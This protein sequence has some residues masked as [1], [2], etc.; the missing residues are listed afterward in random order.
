MNIIGISGRIG[1]GKDTVHQLLTQHYENM[2]Y[3]CT[4]L[5]FAKPIKDICTSMFDWDRERLEYDFP[6][7]E[8][9]TLDDGSLDPACQMLK[10]TRR[11]VMQKIGTDAMRNGLHYDVWVIAM[12]LAIAR[13]DYDEFDYGFIPDCRFI[14]ELSFVKS[15]NGKCIQVR[16]IGEQTTLTDKTDHISET[17]WQQWTDWSC[18]A[19][20]II[21]P[22]LTIKENKDIFKIALLKGMGEKNG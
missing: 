22:N 5:S 16:R 8:G 11:E 10:M 21:D 9:N 15:M 14:N 18:I 2:G 20:N 6:Y 1:A 19:D 4:K 13:G 17:E 7:K 12:K 3:K